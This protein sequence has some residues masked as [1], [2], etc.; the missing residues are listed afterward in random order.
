MIKLSEKGPELAYYLAKNP[1]YVHR[2]NGM[3]TA[4]AVFE[5]G[6]LEAK[7]S[8]VTA[9]VNGGTTPRKSLEDMSADEHE[10]QSMDDCVRMRKRNKK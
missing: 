10:A 5:L 4:Q 3:G 9:K 7:L 6:K 2:L 1:S 8:A